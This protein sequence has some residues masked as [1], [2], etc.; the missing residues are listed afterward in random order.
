[1]RYYDKLIRFKQGSWK[2]NYEQNYRLTWLLE[3]FLDFQV[4][5]V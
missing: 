4:D 5:I 1:M 2:Q 3:C